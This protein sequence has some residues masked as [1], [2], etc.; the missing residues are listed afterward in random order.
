[1][2]NKN[3]LTTTKSRKQLRKLQRKEK[4]AKKNDYYKNRNKS[5][6]NVQIIEEKDDEKSDHP[7]KKSLVKPKVK[8]R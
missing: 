7:L 8:V 1:M 6:K 4:K 3:N 5:G 2:S